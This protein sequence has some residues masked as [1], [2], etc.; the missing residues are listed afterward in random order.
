M[1]FK[2][3]TTDSWTSGLCFYYNKVLLSPY[4]CRWWGNI[5]LT[6]V[7]VFSN[8]NADMW[9][10]VDEPG[11]YF[12]A[13]FENAIS[14]IKWVL[15]TESKA[16]ITITS[17]FTSGYSHSLCARLPTCNRRGSAVVLS[18]RVQKHIQSLVVR[19]VHQIHLLQHVHIH[20]HGWHAAY[21]FCTQQKVNEV[22]ANTAAERGSNSGIVF[23][24]Q[25]QMGMFKLD[26]I[27]SG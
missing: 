7:H 4:F 25:K 27:Q 1:S 8:T 3:K 9:F 6:S 26:G 19:H 16:S 5:Y 24:L 18:S 10:V 2:G 12:N 21:W 17:L 14:K 15:C 22:L 11:W 20:L 23:F 13:Q